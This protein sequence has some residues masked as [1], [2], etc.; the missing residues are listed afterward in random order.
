MDLIS[1][2]L[3]VA[4]GVGKVEIMTKTQALLNFTN[5]LQPWSYS[6]IPLV[7]LPQ[8]MRRGTAHCLIYDYYNV[9]LCHL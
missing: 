3:V 7:T 4:V 1:L 2:R 8:V 6:I 9:T 5:V